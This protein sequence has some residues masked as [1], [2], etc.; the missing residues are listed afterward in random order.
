MR[1][2]IWYHCATRGPGID[3]DWAYRLIAG[4]MMNLSL[5]GLAEAANEIHIGCNGTD[6]DALAPASVAPFNATVE[7]FP[8]GQSELTTLSRLQRWLPEHRGWYVLWFHT[9]GLSYPKNP[10]WDNWRNCMTKVCLWNWEDCVDLLAKGYD[11]VGAHW[12]TH[13]KYSMIPPG[14]RYWGGNFFW[15]RSDYLLTL[16]PVASDSRENRYEAE[17]WVGKGTHT[18]RIF[19]FAPHFPMQCPVCDSKNQL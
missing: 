16:P 6:A 12:M 4:Q 13:Q 18:P 7:S 9:K 19:D 17:V 8:G 15:A 5:C 1:L 10:V 11:T 3:E 2:A 14:Q